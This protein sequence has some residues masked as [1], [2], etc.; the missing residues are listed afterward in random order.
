MTGVV[1]LRT[2]QRSVLGYLAKPVSRAFGGA[3]NER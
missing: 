3:M 2:G 1:D